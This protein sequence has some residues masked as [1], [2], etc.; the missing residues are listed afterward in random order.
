ME[1][2]SLKGRKFGR[3]KVLGLDNHKPVRWLCECRCGK[4]LSVR[5]R[6]LKTGNTKSCG[7][8]VIDVTR[9]LGLASLLPDG[10]AARNRVLDYYKRNAKGKGL[11]WE[12][13]LE[14]FTELVKSPC[15]YC[16]SLPQ[17]VFKKH[18]SSSIFIRNGID[19][20]DSAIGYIKENAV[21]C[22]WECNRLKSAVSLSEFKERIGKIYRHMELD[23]E[24]IG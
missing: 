9:R 24:V 7:C 16:G 21:P 22:C 11:V 12:L 10:Q 3:L 5:A 19:R 1:I 15:S 17:R 6:S 2:E 18:H 4:R 14:D 20:K 13:S 8:L 23:K